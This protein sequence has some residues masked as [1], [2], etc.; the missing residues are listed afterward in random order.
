MA[1][2]VIPIVVALMNG[3]TY[4]FA[5]GFSGFGVI[6]YFLNIFLIHWFAARRAPWLT[7]AGGLEL[8][9]GT[10]IVPGWVSEIG[11]WGMGFIPSGLIVALLIALDVVVDRG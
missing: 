5:F 1:G 10:H 2:V 4:S 11:L 8:T 7:K 6:L 9:A 3:S